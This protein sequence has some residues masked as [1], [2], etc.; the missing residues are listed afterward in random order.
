MARSSR[1][2]VT[3]RAKGQLLDQTDD[4]GLSNVLVWQDHGMRWWLSGTTASGDRITIGA[5]TKRAL[6]AFIKQCVY[7]AEN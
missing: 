3:D 5:R 2:R 1:L 7:P 6:L 4:A